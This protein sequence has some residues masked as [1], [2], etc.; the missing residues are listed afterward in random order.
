M[1]LSRYLYTGP[2][3]AASLRVGKE[4]MLLDV[5]LL[6]GQ[7]V[8]LPPD[9][10]YTLALLTLNHLTPWPAQ[11][12]AEPAPTPSALEKKGAKSHGR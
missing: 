8:E 2:Q 6:S 5:Q 11:A 10:E 3:S 4:R 1:N 7:P 9:H 12:A